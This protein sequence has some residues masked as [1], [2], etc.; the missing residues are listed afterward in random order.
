MCQIWFDMSS[1]NNWRFG[2]PFL[3]KY[4]FSYNVDKKLIGF[5]N[6]ET[7][8]KIIPVKSENN[9]IFAFMIIL[10]LLMVVVVL[11]YYLTKKFCKEKIIQNKA[12]KLMELSEDL[13]TNDKYSINSA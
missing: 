12:Q 13:G 2:K 6:M 9:N 1:R 5:Y 11:S 8:P 4:F 7:K 3:K 10:L